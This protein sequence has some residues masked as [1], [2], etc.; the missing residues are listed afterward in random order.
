MVE[1]RLAAA[2]EL[3]EARCVQQHAFGQDP[4]LVAAE[5]HVGVQLAGLPQP[6]R[7]VHPPGQPILDAA[8][9]QVDGAADRVGAVPGRGRS[10][11]HLDPDQPRAHGEVVGGRRGVGRRR[12]QHAVLH[13]RDLG[14]AVAVGS[15]DADVRTQPVAIFAA[16][17]DAGHAAE[18]LLDVVVL[19]ALQL[20]L[21]QQ[22]RAPGHP[23]RARLVRHDD[24]H[25]D[26]VVELVRSLLVLGRGK[27]RRHQEQGGHPREQPAQR[28]KPGREQV[29][30]VV[31]ARESEARGGCL[32]QLE[33]ARHAVPYGQ[34]GPEVVALLDPV[35]AVVDLVLGRAEQ[36]PLEARGEA[37]PDVAVAQVPE[38][39]VE[40]QPRGR[41]AHQRPVRGR[42]AEEIEEAGGDQAGD[43]HAAELVEQ[44]LQRVDAVEGQRR[45]HLGAVVHLV[46][47]PE[48]RHPV[49]QR[50]EQEARGVPGQEQAEAVGDHDHPRRPLP[51]LGPSQAGVQPP[52]AVGG[53]QPGAAEAR[54][55]AQR[56]EQPSPE[57]ELN[58]QD[59]G[60][61]A[62]RGPDPGQGPGGSSHQQ[63]DRRD[64]PGQGQSRP[65]GPAGRVQQ[66]LSQLR[67]HPADGLSRCHPPPHSG[68]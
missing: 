51:G 2:V 36:P 45:E 42:A 44:R 56:P 22:V 23:G 66:R 10:L 62:Q 61:V 16:G 24:G 47:G 13:Q 41:H 21:A 19:E 31:A 39:H 68:R 1:A 29:V 46:Q 37:Q 58:V 4:R 64:Q 30:A 48:R 67:D 32:G 60:R 28:P 3:L 49:H 6:A 55:P 65:P 52:H 5:A 63:V 50:V 14:A 27:R 43:Q 12:E 7:E 11:E 8:R 17:R 15:P 26:L 35:S 54:G 38:D 33:R 34:P 53:E 9:A 57:H 18:H 20:L 25:A 59:R 40:Q